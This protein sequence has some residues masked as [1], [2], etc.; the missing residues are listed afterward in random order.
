MRGCLPNGSISLDSYEPWQGLD[1]HSKQKFMKG[2][3]RW[4]HGD[5]SRK[6]QLA[7]TLLTSEGLWSQIKEFA[8]FKYQVT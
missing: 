1:H 4:N 3:M 6:N 8:Q 2:Q 5:F 7:H